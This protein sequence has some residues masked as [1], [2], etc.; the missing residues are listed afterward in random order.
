MW[1]VWERGGVHRLFGWENLS[2]EDNLEDPGVEGML[3]IKWIFEKWN[4][5][6][7]T[8]LRWFRIGTGGGHLL[9]REF[10]D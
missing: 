10:L 2:E 6:A 4:G 7:W 3:I 1:H 8:E 5:E 9:C